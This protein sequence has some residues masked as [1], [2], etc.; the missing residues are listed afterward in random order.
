MGLL[1]DGKWHD[2]WY[3]TKESGGAFKRQESNFRNWVT[4]DGSTGPSGDEGFKAEPDRY[5]LYVSH[6]CP[7]AH[8]TLIFRSLKQLGPLIDISV[9]HLSLIHI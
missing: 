9:V 5:H 8:R 7:W 1:I 6:A 2:S 4:A 3:D